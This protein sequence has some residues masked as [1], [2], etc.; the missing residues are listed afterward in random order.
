MRAG[1]VW[2]QPTTA[3][4]AL[5][6]H[7]QAFPNL[8]VAK[9]A[10]G[11]EAHLS[12]GCAW[13]HHQLTEVHVAMVPGVEMGAVLKGCLATY[14]E[15]AT[16]VTCFL[17]NPLV[18]ERVTHPLG[19]YQAAVERMTCILVWQGWAWAL[20]KGMEPERMA[21]GHGGYSQGSQH[22]R[23]AQGSVPETTLM[24]GARLVCEG[25]RVA[26]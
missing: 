7:L 11:Q 18:W 2:Q 24:G 10:C 1:L 25:W 6:P 21:R 4:E 13:E 17:W 19:G 3:A 9:V 20:A 14:Q 26:S 16:T 8:E 23:G 22:Q 12:V 15:W 5:G